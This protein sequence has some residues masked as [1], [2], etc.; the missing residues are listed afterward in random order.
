MMKKWKNFIMELKII[1]GKGNRF[2]YHRKRKKIFIW[3]NFFLKDQNLR[4]LD[5]NNINYYNF[6]KKNTLHFH[7]K[8]FW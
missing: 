8:N 4:Y 2:L 6:Y 3:C 1:N 5:I 7:L